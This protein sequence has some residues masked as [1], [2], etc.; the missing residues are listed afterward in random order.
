MTERS[1]RHTKAAGS[2]QAQRQRS[3]PGRGR[4]RGDRGPRAHR[5]LAA[6]AQ[7]PRPHP[8]DGRDVRDPRVQDRRPPGRPE[9]RPDRDPGRRPTRRSTRSSATSSSTA[10]RRSIPRTRTTRPGRHRRRVSRGLLQHDQPADPG[11]PRRALGRR[12]D[13][14][15]DCGIVVEPGRRQAALHA[16]EPRR[17]SACRSWSGTR[18][19]ACCRSSGRAR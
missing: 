8:A 12:A 1:N 10:P 15:M 13:Q 16:D 11:P 7:D 6:P 17:R 3:Q 9:L 5:R 19:C 2:R 4:D 14:E 18:A